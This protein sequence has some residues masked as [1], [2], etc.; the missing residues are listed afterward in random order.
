MKNKMKKYSETV[1]ALFVALLSSLF[2]CSNSIAAEP[3]EMQLETDSVTV[4]ELLLYYDLEDLINVA[5]RRP[6]KL[7]Y[8]AE[9][10][11]II[12]AEEIRAMNAHSVAEVLNTV[13]GVRVGFRGGN[14][15]GSAALAIQES[16][17]EHVLLLLD[18]VR[19]NDV[20]AG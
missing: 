10:I 6:T 20:D 16:S 9:N 11:S 14:F 12:T 5:Y 4:R 13:P 1:V 17:Y 3:E 18:G 19:L 15:G 7:R 2:L 8:V